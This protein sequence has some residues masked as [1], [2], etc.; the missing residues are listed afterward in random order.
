MGE[1]QALNRFFH[2]LSLFPDI[3]PLPLDPNGFDVISFKGEQYKYATGYENFI[4]TL[5]KK[6]PDEHENLKRYA[7]GVKKVAHSSPFH[8][9]YNPDDPF[10]F[11]SDYAT[12]SVNNFIDTFT[13]NEV[14]QNVL[15]GEIPLYAGVRD[16]TPLYVHA[17]INDSN[18][19]GA[20]R[21][22]GGS[23]QI[24][25]SL[26]RSIRS[27]GGEI[28][29]LSKVSKIICDNSKATGVIMEDGTAV[30]ADYLISN[31]HPE[32]TIEMIDSHLIRPM[33]RNRIRQMEQTIAN[34]TVYLKFKKNTVPYMNH[35]YYHYNGN[36][37]WG[38]ENYT[39]E[40][41]PR[42]YLYM[43]LCPEQLPQYAEAG[44]MLTIMRFEELAQWAGT[45]VEQRGE[46]YRE[47]KQ[48]KAE[49][50]LAQLEC[51]FPGTLANVESYY[52]SS[53]LTYLN[54]TGT[55]NGAAY[56]VLRSINAPR[57]VHRTRIPNLFL[58]GQNTNAHGI[59]GVVIGAVIVCF[60]FLG[61][62][63]LWKQIT[64]CQQ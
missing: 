6:F 19:S 57:I 41:W 39:Q 56:G 63:F 54:Y 21:I 27:F 8:A 46:A 64:E 34:F 33:Y 28:F 22:M 26:V 16:K 35:N 20:C 9:D 11:S 59:M 60:E 48:R 45:Q 61:R 38:C 47:F 53:P 58:A 2:Y 18:I 31:T 23:D 15:V 10:Q 4:A 42:G 50:M 29:A 30:A 25:D 36:Q 13:S 40:D 3:K 1:G 7:E 52:T 32:I 37:I 44:E 14:L 43:H 51:D 12:V 62:E 24:A 5:A 17:F 49:K 55:K